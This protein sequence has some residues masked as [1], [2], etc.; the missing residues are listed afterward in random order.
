MPDKSTNNVNVV[1]RRTRHT[2]SHMLTRPQVRA[3]TPS[4]AHANRLYPEFSINY[5]Y[6]FGLHL[7]HRIPNAVYALRT[8]L[9]CSCLLNAVLFCRLSDAWRGGLHDSAL[10]EFPTKDAGCGREG[11]AWV[12]LM[13]YDWLALAVW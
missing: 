8:Y 13:R 5:V 2:T 12:M 4:H 6:G 1:S 9:H 11:Y 7:P 3:Y 10:V